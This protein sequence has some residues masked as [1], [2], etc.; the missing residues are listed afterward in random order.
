MISASNQHAAPQTARDVTEPL[1]WQL[2]GTR[3]LRQLM[4]GYRYWRPPDTRP[5]A[6]W[7]PAGQIA[8]MVG[9]TV[10]AAAGM[11]MWDL[12]AGLGL[13]E[14]GDELVV[15]DIL[16]GGHPTPIRRK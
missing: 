12:L 16:A 9:L 5:Y 6:A 3:H 7:R 4:Q 14:H 10:L 13:V 8:A 15:K 2:A 11:A 1:L